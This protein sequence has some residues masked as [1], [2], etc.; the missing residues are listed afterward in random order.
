MLSDWR[1]TLVILDTLFL[2]SILSRLFILKSFKTCNS[3]INS[4]NQIITSCI[5]QQQS[6]DSFT[7]NLFEFQILFQFRTIFDILIDDLLLCH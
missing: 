5:T 2:T 1:W 6:F 7:F 3:R 4:I